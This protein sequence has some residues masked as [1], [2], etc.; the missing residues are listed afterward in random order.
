MVSLKIP[1]KPTEKCKDKLICHMSK[2]VY[3]ISLL[4]YYEK[5]FGKK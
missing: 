5:P 1:L 3:I 2:L 4:T